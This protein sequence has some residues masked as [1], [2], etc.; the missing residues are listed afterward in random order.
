MMTFR[1]SSTPSVGVDLVAPEDKRAIPS[2]DGL[3]AFS[4]LAVILGHTR[5]ATLDHLR[6][7]AIFRNGGQGVTVFFVLSGFLITHLLLK[8]KARYGAIDLREFYFR[9]TL[10]IFP[11]F[12]MFLLVVLIASLFHIVA[13]DA[14]AF[15]SALTY[16]WNYVPQK[17]DV[18]ILGH[19][20]SLSLE[21]QFYLL[22]PL[23]VAKFSR[24]TCLR[25]VIAIIVLSPVSRVITYFAWPSMRTH[26]DSIMM[27]CLLTLLLDMDLWRMARSLALSAWAPLLALTFLFGIATPAERRW[28]GNYQITVGISLENVAVAIIILFAVFRHQSVLGRV[29]NWK[30]IRHIGMISYS[31]YLWQQP[32][33]GPLTRNLGLSLLCSFVCAELSY[34]IVEKPSLR[35]RAVL[36]R[37]LFG[38][39][40][41]RDLKRA[42]PVSL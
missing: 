16:T 42:E 1:R 22:W 34:F 8:E 35:L 39:Q 27:G 28:G 14:R 3:R 31:L 20:W 21:E 40:M 2:L 23:C 19:C 4:V 30:P 38:K 5:D 15:L 41:V 36:Q 9:R 11:P 6:F 17:G 7:L 26:V 25:I 12:Y 33:T 32:F 29:L 24:L 10:R 13:I 37:R 18:W